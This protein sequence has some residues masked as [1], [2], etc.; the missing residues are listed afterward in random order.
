[1]TDALVS[2]APLSGLEPLKMPDYANHW[3]HSKYVYQ[4]VMQRKVCILCY[5]A[6]FWNPTSL[7]LKFLCLKNK[8]QKT[9]QHCYL[10]SQFP[11][12]PPQ[13]LY[14]KLFCWQ[15]GE[16]PSLWHF[17][18][19]RS[20]TDVFISAVPCIFGKGWSLGFLNVKSSESLALINYLKQWFFKKQ[21]QQHPT[22]RGGGIIAKG[23]I[24]T[25]MQS[26]FFLG[27]ACGREI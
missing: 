10:G 21:Q 7:V 4:W 8:R 5:W 17:K 6:S 20:C 27:F 2:S 3:G 25:R 26:N 24:Y 11:Q 1:M 14:G 22:I 9:M 19:L 15:F 16:G 13:T 12:L 23:A 18:D